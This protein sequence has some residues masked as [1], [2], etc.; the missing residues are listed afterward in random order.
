MVATKVQTRAA[1]RKAEAEAAAEAER[2]LSEKIGAARK[3]F[4]AKVA[5]RPV[6]THRV[7]GMTG[8]V[9]VF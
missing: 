8:R 3:V 5:A 6:K 9:D 1:K 2:Q 4:K 7:V